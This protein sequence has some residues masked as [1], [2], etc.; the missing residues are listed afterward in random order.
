VNVIH[1]NTTDGTGGAGRA[2]RRLHDA[3]EQH[4]ITSHLVVGSKQSGDPDATEISAA[5]RPIAGRL[6]RLEKVLPRLNRFPGEM[7]LPYPSSRQFDRTGLFKGADLVHL[8]NLHGKYFDYRVLPRW[9]TTRPIVWTL[10]DMW[11][12]TGH[13]AFSLDCPRWQRGCGEC[14]MFLPGMKRL[15]AIPQPLWDNSAPEWVRKRATYAKTPLAIVAPSRWLLDLASQSMLASHPETVFLQIPYGLDTDRYRPIA[16]PEARRLLGLEQDRPMLFFGAADVADERKGA[17]HLLNAL[18]GPELA[19]YEPQ[20]LTI[21]KAAGL[22]HEYSAVRSFGTVDDEALQALIYSAAD[23]ALAPSIADNQPLIALEAMACGT[24]VVAFAV[25]GLPEIVRDG[26]S[27][28]C[29]PRSD[30][31]ALAAAVAPLLAN[32]DLHDRLS[33]AARRLVLA[34]HALSRYASSYRDIYL[35]RTAWF[36]ERARRQE[37]PAV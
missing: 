31:V 16:K 9:S 22:E 8:H 12:L 28:F 13:C 11:P 36:G 19:P 20:L 33:E 26:V 24:P 3:L 30:S 14:P 4:G 17:R 5:V 21:G 35:E 23:V 2:A 27:G 32:P 29:V 37:A 34:E 25:G 15:D 18:H 6:P 1:V 7:A 10:H